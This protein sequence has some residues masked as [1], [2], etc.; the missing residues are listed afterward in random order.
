MNTLMKHTLTIFIVL[1]L[2]PLAVL[3]AANTPSPV[4]F[5]YRPNGMVMWDSW[6][7]EDRGQ[8]HMFHL[9]H[10]PPNSKRSAMEAN[11]IGHAVS[12]DLIHWTEQPL[13]VGPGADGGLDDM[14]PW[15]GCAVVRE[16]TFHLFY[17]MRSSREE[18]RCQRI[19]PAADGWLD[20]RRQNQNR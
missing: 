13:T 11:H 1:L 9:Q 5:G 19:D 18:A 4:G 12:R 6:F 10:L 17:T 2:V 14:Q 16:G 3:Q 15:T 7:V 8:V 20:V